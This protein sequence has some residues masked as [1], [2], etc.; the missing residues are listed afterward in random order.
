MGFDPNGGQGGGGWPPGGG[1]GGQGGWPPAPGAPAPGQGGP[2]GAPQQ[3]QQPAF[4]APPA[5]PGFGAP[6][7][8]PAFGAP[9]A[10][11][12]FGAP[13]PQQGFGA[14][15]QPGFGAPQPGFGAPQQGGFG[16]PAQGGFGAAQGA[17]VPMGG[18]YGGMQGAMIPG[19]VSDKDQGTAFLISIFL[20]AYGGDR[21]YLGQ[22]GLGVAKLLTCGGLGVWAIIDSIMIGMGKMRDMQGRPLRT[23]PIVGTPTRSQS[24]AFL[25]SYFVGLFG[26]DRFYLGQTGLG[27]A[28]LLT[29]G[30]F[31]IWW[32]IDLI[33]IGMGKMKDAQG[34]SLL[35]E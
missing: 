26:G 15:Q 31:G 3:P 21:F 6:P 30:G 18:G 14:P 28:K 35:P 2:F 34:N 27:I 22:T 17:M 4:G 33:L 5:Q 8:Q 29:C 23:D 9:P 19:G 24:V 1:G 10:Q 7:A 13:Q 12:G 11:P 16:A 20:G 25:L 32:L